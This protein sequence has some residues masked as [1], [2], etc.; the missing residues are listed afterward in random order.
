VTEPTNDAAHAPTEKR[1]SPLWHLTLSR[2]LEFFREPEAIFW[3]YGFPLIMTFLLGVAF[4]NKAAEKISVDVLQGS[5]P[6][7]EALAAAG[8]F[9]AT[10]SDELAAARRLRTGKTPLVASWKD[11]RAVLTFDP[12]NPEG[13]SVRQAVDDALQR[14]AGRKDPTTVVTQH[15][16]EPGGRYVDFLVPGLLGMGVMG[17][18]L[19]GV[20]FVI[21]DMRIRKVL[22]RFLATPMRRSDFLL[23][24]MFS[25]LLFLIP[26]VLILILFAM[27][28]F[29]FRIFGSLWLVTFV[30]LLGSFAFS[31]IGLLVA[32]RAKTIEAVSGLMNLVMLPMWLLSGIFFS[33]DRFPKEMQAFIKPLP[34]TA[35]LDALRA[36]MLEGAGLWEIAAPVAMLAAW[37]VVSFAVALKIFR[38]Y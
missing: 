12:D 15:R 1:Y 32:S 19:W 28:G 22:K 4:Q 7:V 9:D 35:L 18:G 30:I 33:A 24:L 3:V 26:E 13:R 31:G 27:W 38:W 10:I 36:V 2:L 14:R 8:H 5:T 17:G 16:Q 25:R 34:L 37:A 11:G 23:A 29:G 6:I 20:G 21:V